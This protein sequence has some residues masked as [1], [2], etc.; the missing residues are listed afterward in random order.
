ML[1]AIK[2]LISEVNLRCLNQ[3]IEEIQN[4]ADMKLIWI[5]AMVFILDGNSEIDAHV[6]SNL[7][8]FKAFD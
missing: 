5:F 6:R 3:I 8:V 4:K 1:S 7:R 2:S